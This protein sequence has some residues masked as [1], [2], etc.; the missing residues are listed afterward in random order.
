M[1]KILFIISSL[2]ASWWA[3]KVI[4]II[5]N[6]LIK[7]WYY[8]E[9]LTFYKSTDKYTFIGK[10]YCIE[11]LLSK[12]IIYNTFKIFKRAYII[13]SYCKKMNFDISISFMEEANF[14]NIIS[15]SIFWNKSKCFIAIRQSQNYIRKLFKIL[16][17]IFYKKADLIITNSKEEELN[18]KR[19][20]KVNKIT[21]IYNP[22][23]SF[24]KTNEIKTSIPILESKKFKFINIWRLTHQK[25]HIL[26]IKAFEKIYQKNKNLI[27]IIIWGWELENQLKSYVKEKNLENCIYILWHQK[28][29]NYFLDNSNCFVFSSL[30]EGF[31]NAILEAMSSWLPIIST[32]CKTGPK[33]ILWETINN[34]DE[35]PKISMEEYWILVPNNNILELSKAM[36]LIIND[37]KLYQYYKNKSKERINKFNLDNITKFWEKII[38][39][40]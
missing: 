14:P 9:I 16:G 36:E 35:T 40:I 39:K 34:F 29:V 37:K 1:K 19:S 12:N 33:E 15:K 21:T 4:T 30:R 8:V 22:I 10:E 6:E 32:D 26:L 5:A 11:E 2:T 17:H 7:K 25:N 27:L 38:N 20:F 28:N 18:I 3:W 31:P 24:E 13:N 23:F